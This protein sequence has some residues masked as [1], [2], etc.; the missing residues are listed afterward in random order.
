M[1]ILKIKRNK[2]HY[3]GNPIKEIHEIFTNFQYLYLKKVLSN[4]PCE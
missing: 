3:K 1:M 4:Q 2:E